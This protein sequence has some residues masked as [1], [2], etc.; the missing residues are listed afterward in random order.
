M[1]GAISPLPYAFTACTEAAIPFHRDKYVLQEEVELEELL[2]GKN[3]STMAEHGTC[4]S[5]VLDAC[6]ADFKNSYSGGI[7][8]TA[9]IKGFCVCVYQT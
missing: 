3:F 2:V 4:G 1:G 7:C 5:T 8:C 6:G 9:F